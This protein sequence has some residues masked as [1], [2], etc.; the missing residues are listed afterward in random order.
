MADDEEGLSKKFNRNM[1]RLADEAQT[2]VGQIH[3]AEEKM[4]DASA[5]LQEV[6]TACAEPDGANPDAV[7][8]L[9]SGNVSILS[10]S[11]PQVGCCAASEERTASIEP[12]EAHLDQ[13]GDTSYMMAIKLK[14]LKTGSTLKVLEKRLVKDWPAVQ[15]GFGKGAGKGH[16]KKSSTGNTAGIVGGEAL[17]VGD[18]SL[19]MAEI[20]RAS[21][22][23]R[24]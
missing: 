9:G 14:G 2:R 24:V 17:Q 13:F 12:D 5:L 19:N 20:G 23:E 16:G 8:Y 4:D 1:N 10:F 7:P 11:S 15:P 18:M 22:R 6:V 3:D 21:C